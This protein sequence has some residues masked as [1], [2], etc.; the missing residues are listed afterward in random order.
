M[1]IHFRMSMFSSFCVFVFSF[2]GTSLDLFQ[3][4]TLN[5]HDDTNF[6]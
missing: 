1:S 4:I 2:L 6:L 5:D 3:Q